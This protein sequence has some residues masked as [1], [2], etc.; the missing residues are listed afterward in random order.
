[1]KVAKYAIAGNSIVNNLPQTAA[2]VQP[3]AESLLK[4]LKCGSDRT[5]DP[6]LEWF[7]CSDAGGGPVEDAIAASCG[8]D[9]RGAGA[10]AV[11][12]YGVMVLGGVAIVFGLRR[13]G[14]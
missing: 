8:D 10:V 1:M 5:S 4:V 11:A 12:L 7:P 13:P 6:E 14:A 2:V 9:D 3:K